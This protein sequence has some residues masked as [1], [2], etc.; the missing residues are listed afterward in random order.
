MSRL[1]SITGSGLQPLVVKDYAIGRAVKYHGDMANPSGI[2]AIV[3]IRPAGQYGPKSYDV[4]L[5]DG[6]QILG[7]YL[8]GSR[9]TVT[10][11][12]V[13]PD[14]VDILRA[15]VAA[16]EAADKAKASSSKQAFSEAV[17]NLR[18]AHPELTQG[19]G[20]VIAA[21]NIR[22]ELKRAFPS[23][24]FSVRTSKFSGGNSVDV[25][26]TDGPTS[27]QVEAITNKYEAGSFDGMTDSYDYK[28]SAW[29]EVY[30]D[31]KYI[32]CS[33]HSS[34]KM[35]EFVIRMVCDR[36]GGMDARPSVEDYRRGELWKFKQSGGC[37]VQREINA[38]L[39]KHTYCIGGGHV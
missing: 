12:H 21:K 26:W 33:R 4:A 1:Y 5:I 11:E 7:T 30:G 31:A 34:D 13:A 28:R 22:T 20:P 15:G 19:S 39:S 23:V 16:K 9:W 18:A 6:R 32:H 38:A 2:G 37:D 14:A 35:V 29:T 27:K 25:S 17:A 10:D 3:A 36:L 8:D 24:A